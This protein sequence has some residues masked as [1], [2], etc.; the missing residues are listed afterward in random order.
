MTKYVC[1]IEFYDFHPNR[2]GVCCVW[3]RFGMFACVRV[4]VCVVD[5][6]WHHHRRCLHVFQ[7]YVFH[8]G[9][10]SLVYYLPNGNAL[11]FLRIYRGN[12]KRTLAGTGALSGR[13]ECGALR[14]PRGTFA[15]QSHMQNTFW[16]SLRKLVYYISSLLY[17]KALHWFW[18]AEP[19]NRSYFAADELSL[20]F[21]CYDR[22]YSPAGGK[23][24]KS[25]LLII[26]LIS[27]VL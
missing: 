16:L 15:A 26:N 23:M 5:G 27:V 18:L 22:L 19:A 7:M 4:R 24:A 20:A 25:I 8:C 3:M 9:C 6:E 2:M 13:Y 11:D 10:L 12:C 1:W 17:F 14:F 21:I